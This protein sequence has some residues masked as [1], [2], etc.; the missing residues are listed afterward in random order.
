MIKLKN[1]ILTDKEGIPI[2]PRDLP[3]LE[4]QYDTAYF[5][6]K[7]SIN[8]NGD[9]TFSSQGANKI[10][11]DLGENIPTISID[12]VYK[13]PNNSTLSINYVLHQFP[14]ATRRTAKVWFEHPS[15]IR[16]F[17]TNYVYFTGEFPKE[18]ML[19]NLTSLQLSRN[20]FDSFPSIL[21][22]GIFSN[23][24]INEMTLN[25][26]NNIPSWITNSKITFLRLEHRLDFRDKDINN[27]DKLVNV[28]N[29]TSLTITA[30]LNT[31]SFPDNF[32]DIKDLK[33][34]SFSQS[35]LAEL[36]QQITD[37]KQLLSLG[38][39]YYLSTTN[40][41]SFKRWGTGITDMNLTSMSF[42]GCYSM[43]TDA[44]VGIETVPSLKTYNT[45]S[46]YKTQLR[47]DEA[48]TSMYNKVDTFASKSTGNTLL[49][50]VNW[51][52]SVVTTAWGMNT[53]PTGTYQQPTGF[54]LGSDNG[55]PASPME[56]VWVLVNQYKWKITL[57]N[58]SGNGTETFQ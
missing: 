48:I 36:P 50:Q 45:G 16:T 42:G 29:L 43:P 46:S 53:R 23:L 49:R 8:G 31:N 35:S 12:F 3:I 21:K 44:P 38:A 24:I 22:G 41:N 17:G 5:P 39:G 51:F 34:F 47:I 9:W 19:F 18:L 14:N 52:N 25:T 27:L 40:N 55:S 33:S 2:K 4:L 54:I 10:Y 37:C 32:K 1:N 20:R 57:T 58:S 26:M 13:N 28:K 30:Q 11:I 7:Q 15:R 56:M 6:P